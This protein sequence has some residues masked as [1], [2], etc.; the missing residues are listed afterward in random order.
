MATLVDV[1]V[2]R[3]TRQVRTTDLGG[4]RPETRSATIEGFDSV[5]ASVHTPVRFGRAGDFA[6]EPSSGIYVPIES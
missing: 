4:R 6:F 1:R 2:G 5:I 3:G